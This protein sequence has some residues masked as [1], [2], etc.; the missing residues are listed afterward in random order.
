MKNSP[1]MNSC[2]APR[3]AANGNAALL[4]WAE[5]QAWRGGSASVVDFGF[6]GC[7]LRVDDFPPRGG[8]AWLCLAATGPSPWLQGTVIATI[9]KGRFSWVR[10]LVHLR[11]LEPCPYDV[12]KAAIGGFSRSWTV[13]EF[14]SSRFSERDWQ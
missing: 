3:Y 13:P 14:E 8:A 7:T 5:G 10:R 11:F 9:K 4:V 6:D 2:S 12:F 1:G